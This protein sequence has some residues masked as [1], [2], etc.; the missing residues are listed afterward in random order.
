[1][2]SG[3][4]SPISAN[5]DEEQEERG[6]SGV[7]NVRRTEVRSTRGTR[8]VGGTFI[9]FAREDLSLTFSFFPRCGL[10]FDD[11]TAK[12]AV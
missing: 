12:N 7:K 2:S 10:F 8:N 1:M 5:E 11:V 9:A 3:S 4:S 6:A